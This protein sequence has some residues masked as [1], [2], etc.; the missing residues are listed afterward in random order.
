A[1]SDLAGESLCF[2][3]DPDGDALQLVAR[4]GGRLR[5]GSHP[6]DLRR[7]GHPLTVA[8]LEPGPVLLSG[9]E[10][11]RG[12]GIGLRSGAMWAIPLRRP[13]G[14]DERGLGLLLCTARPSERA[15]DA[16]VMWLVEL[17]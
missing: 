16:R 14:A 8:L 4:S 1:E 3:T 11:E 17:L 2:A 15:P 10:L 13:E 12:S 6:V 5:A 7:A 9:P